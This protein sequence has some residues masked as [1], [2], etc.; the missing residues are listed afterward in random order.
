MHIGWLLVLHVDV[1]M[2]VLN[3]VVEDR[4]ETVNAGKNWGI[5]QYSFHLALPRAGNDLCSENLG[6]GMGPL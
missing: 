6:E 5:V 4:A 1:P 3:Q 2:D